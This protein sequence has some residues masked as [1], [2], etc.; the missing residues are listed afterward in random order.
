MTNTPKKSE[1]KAP[2]RKGKFSLLSKFAGLFG[3]KAEKELV[4]ALDTPAPHKKA[5]TFSK[6]VSLTPEQE[7]KLQ[8][9]VAKIQE[10]GKEIYITYRENAT[11]DPII[12]LIV[13]FLQQGGVQ[14]GVKAF[15]KETTKETIEQWKTSEPQ[16]ENCM[17]LTDMTC[18]SYEKRK[19][20]VVLDTF[21]T[22]IIES[23]LAWEY[24]DEWNKL[25][26]ETLKGDVRK[27][28]EALEAEGKSGEE[29]MLMSYD[30]ETEV[31]KNSP[32]YQ[33]MVAMYQKIFQDIVRSRLNHHTPDHIYLVYDHANDHG[34]SVQILGWVSKS[35]TDDKYDLEA[36]ENLVRDFWGPID[37][38]QEEKDAFVKLHKDAFR[39]DWG[40]YYTAIKTLYI[41]ICQKMENMIREAWYNGMVSIISSKDTHSID[42]ANAWII[43][44]RHALNDM[45]QDSKADLIPLPLFDMVADTM[46]KWYLG[47]DINAKLNKTE[48]SVDLIQ[49]LASKA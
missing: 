20:Y 13:S 16:R 48:L 36:T 14:V 38:S 46:E 37:G 41:Q 4:D 43:Y 40:Y 15:P 28:K 17:N 44:D 42:D 24:A 30:I 3:E 5:V 26:E 32:A 49:S 27:R 18:E 6:D 1:N 33:E 45:K 7:E 35:T 22:E 29:I 34:Q 10:S 21:F 39:A 2:A 11:Y 12:R 47:E 19:N 31:A 8:A 9:A 23:L 25:C